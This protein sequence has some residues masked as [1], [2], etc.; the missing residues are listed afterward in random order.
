MLQQLGGRKMLAISASPFDVFLACEN[1]PLVVHDMF[2][3][4]VMILQFKGRT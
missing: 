1:W 3:P 4:I 2:R